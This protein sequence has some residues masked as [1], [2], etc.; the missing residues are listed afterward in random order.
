MLVENI[1]CNVPTKG[2]INKR[3]PFF[4]VC[5]K[6]QSIEIINKIAFIK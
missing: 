1:V 2:K 3:Q 5:G 6:A 4:V